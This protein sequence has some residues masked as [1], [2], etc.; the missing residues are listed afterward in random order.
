MAACV[1][2]SYHDRHKD[3]PCGRCAPITRVNMHLLKIAKDPRKY[4]RVC[5]ADSGSAT[6]ALDWVTCPDCAQWMLENDI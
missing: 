5:G 2:T 3:G 1:N 6:T 4:E